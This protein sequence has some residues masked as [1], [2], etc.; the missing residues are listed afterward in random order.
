MTDYERLC[1]KC[2]Q[3]IWGSYAYCPHCGVARNLPLFVP[4]D[5]LL[6]VDLEDLDDCTLTAK[7]LTRKQ[8][9]RLKALAEPNSATGAL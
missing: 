6:W 7:P 8:L 4:N 3:W 9:S 5:E 2:N 1:E